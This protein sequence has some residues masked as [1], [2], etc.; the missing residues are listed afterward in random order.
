[1]FSSNTF[2][3][4]SFSYPNSSQVLHTTLSTQL[5]VSSFCLSKKWGKTT[6]KRK[7]KQAAFEK[8]N[9]TKNNKTIYTHR[10]KYG[11]CFVLVNYPRAWSLSS[12]VLDIY[13][14]TLHWR[15]LIFPFLGGISCRYLLGQGW[16]SVHTSSSWCQGFL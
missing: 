12:S 8:E 16:D 7:S 15:R 3:S 11:V 13:P 5:L 1:M 6:T 9:Q 4:Y 10:T 14:L 2:G